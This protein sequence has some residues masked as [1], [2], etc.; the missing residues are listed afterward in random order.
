MATW[1]RTGTIS[2]TNGSAT[3]TGSGTAFVANSQVG[4]ALHGPDG[5]I[6]EITAVN[7]NTSLTI[8][9]A[10]LGGT[11]TGQTYTIQP[12]RGWTTRVLDAI[13]ESNTDVETMLAGPG[14]GKFPAGT[15][16]QPG[17]RFLTD[18][19]TGVRLTGTNA[20]ALV[21]GGS[22]KF[23][24]SG[25]T[26][27]G[28][29]VQSAANDATLGKLLT[30][31]AFGTGSSAIDVSD[32]D[33]IVASGLYKISATN[34]AAGNAPTGAG[35]W[36]VQHTQFDTGSRA[37]TA[38]LAGTTNPEIWQRSSLSEAYGSWSRLYAQNN[39]NGTVSQVTGTPTGA[40]FERGSNANGHYVRFADGTQICRG[41]V[42][43]STSAGVA[44][45]FPAAFIDT[46]ATH[47]ATG[48]NTSAGVGILTTYTGI[49]STSVTMS[50]FFSSSN[51]RVATAAEY[52]A[53]GRWF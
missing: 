27:Y 8:T 16:A 30:V 50:A 17:M 36:I 21:G 43:T 39:T 49:T 34:A 6:Y 7:S 1:Y 9:P 18:E 3:A 13:D 15:L 23:G 51:T 42:T 33:A 37:Q 4:D 38:S 14:A 29:V 5:K 31:G 19:D 26:A 52:I 32:L 25:S 47:V 20:L 28:D 12:T 45:T 40:L 35:N 24:V 41:R 46:A 53:T 11:Q 2:V 10:Y 22:D 44:A 48:V